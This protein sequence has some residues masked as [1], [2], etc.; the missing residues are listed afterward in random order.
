MSIVYVCLCEKSTPYCHPGSRD[1]VC[2]YVFATHTPEAVVIESSSERRHGAS[3]RKYRTLDIDRRQ[4]HDGVDKPPSH[5]E[6]AVSQSLSVV[7]RSLTPLAMPRASPSQGFV[8]N[9]PPPLQTPGLTGCCPTLLMLY[10]PPSSAS[11][12]LPAMLRSVSRLLW[13]GERRV[14]IS[15]VALGHCHI[16]DLNPACNTSNTRVSKTERAH[17]TT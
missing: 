12:L 7:S 2:I 4:P 9:R 5:R 10:P 14:S 8:T 6:R 1:P 11:A 13:E 3:I 17:P 15:G 16:S